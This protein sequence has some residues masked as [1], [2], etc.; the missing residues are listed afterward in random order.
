[1]FASLHRERFSVAGWLALGLMLAFSGCTS[2]PKAHAS[3]DTATTQ[4]A[5][6]DFDGGTYCAQTFLQGPAPAQPLHFSNKITESDP[7]LKS[8][9]FEADLAGDSVDLVHR[10]KWLA[11]DDDRKF[12][13]ESAR[14]ADPKI[15]QRV[16]NNGVAEETVTNHALRSDEVGWRGVTMSI[17]QGGTPWGLFLYKP[18]VSRVGEE[19]VNGFD[20][21]KYAVDTTH[22]SA[23]EKSASFLRGVADYNI[24]GTAWVLKDHHCVLQY[25]IT[26][27]QTGKDGKA[28]TTHY[29][30]TVLKK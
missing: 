17:S 6:D 1:M 15:I 25:D 18:T 20:T 3:R 12:F 8:K 2:K 9:D 19:T 14:F 16:I 11:T 27:E 29:E 21:I 10:D 30:G 5:N 24:T 7:S 26:D 28:K 23:M 13:Q 4:A 22:E